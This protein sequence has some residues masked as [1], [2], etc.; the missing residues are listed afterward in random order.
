MNSAFIETLQNVLAPIVQFWRIFENSWKRLEKT[1]ITTKASTAT[2][3][4]T[5]SYVSSTYA[6]P[7]SNTSTL[8]LILTQ[9]TCRCPP[10]CKIFHNYRHYPQIF[11]ILALVQ[12]QRILPTQTLLT[13]AQIITPSYPINQSSPLHDTLGRKAKKE[14]KSSLG[15][16]NHFGFFFFFFY[17]RGAENGKIV[18]SPQRIRGSNPPGTPLG[19]RNWQRG[20]G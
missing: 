8:F 2:I 20:G 17:R 9:A 10:N 11:L 16:F 19:T 18:S 7:R 1:D 3:S 14:R 4:P 12:P 13:L 6:D 15:I 5:F